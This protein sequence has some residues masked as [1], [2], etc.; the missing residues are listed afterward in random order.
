MEEYTGST[1]SLSSLPVAHRLL[2]KSSRDLARVHLSFDHLLRCII[3]TMQSSLR[4]LVVPLTSSSL[5]SGSYISLLLG[6]HGMRW[7]GEA[8]GTLVQ[9]ETRFHTHFVETGE[10]L[11]RCSSTHTGLGI[12]L[13]FYTKDDIKALSSPTLARTGSTGT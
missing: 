5:R 9:S 3:D 6:S 8:H 2:C 11:F 7:I 4:H 10:R 12:I 1:E 13:Y